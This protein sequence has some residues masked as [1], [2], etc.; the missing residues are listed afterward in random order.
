[1]RTA[2]LLLAAAALLHAQD[3]DRPDRHVRLVH[4]G[5]ERR[6]HLH[7]PPRASTPAPLVVVLHGG[8]RS[9]DPVAQIRAATRFDEKADAEG[10]AVVYPEALEGNWNDGRGVT[11]YRSHADNV[12]DVGFIGAV[13]ERAASIARIDRARIYVAGASN[14]GMMA[15]RLACEDPARYAAVAGVIA[16]L[17]SNLRCRPRRSVPLVIINGTDDPLMPWG[18]GYVTFGPQRMGQVMSAEATAGLF[19]EANGCKSTPEFERLP[20]RA[21][22]DGTRVFRGR[23]A[24]CRADVLLYRVEGG[25]HTWP[26]RGRQTAAR[27]IVG[28]TSRDI[29]AT[30]EIWSFFA[31]Q[32]RR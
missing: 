2:V 22:G 1:M 17:P 14:G 31:G 25:G 20:D 3:R 10:F 28:R 32:V 8:G 4:N 23:F 16:N 12:D 18:G 11:R 29:E 15:Y 26:G 5:L 19:A 9:A 21:P 30:D 13:V 24:Q 7:L 6:F 27:A